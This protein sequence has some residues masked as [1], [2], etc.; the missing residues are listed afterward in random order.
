MSEITRKIVEQLKGSRCKKNNCKSQGK[1]QLEVVWFGRQYGQQR[2]ATCSACLICSDE[3]IKNAIPTQL[4]VLPL[5][6]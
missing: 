2:E 3:A 5:R 1:D 6:Y 4:N